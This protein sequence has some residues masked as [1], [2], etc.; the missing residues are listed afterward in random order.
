MEA[1]YYDVTFLY[2]E[3]AEMWECDRR[4]F[5][6]SRTGFFLVHVYMLTSAA[7]LYIELTSFVVSE[8]EKQA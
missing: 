3:W 1:S 5:H 8:G 4:Q 2:L 7:I 6:P